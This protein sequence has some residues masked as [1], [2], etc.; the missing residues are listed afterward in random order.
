MV[1]AASYAASKANARTRFDRLTDCVL[2]YVRYTGMSLSLLTP[3]VE[4]YRAPETN[5][6][7]N[8]DAL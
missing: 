7:V 1:V 2:E 8:N 5:P 4:N 6:C 3:T